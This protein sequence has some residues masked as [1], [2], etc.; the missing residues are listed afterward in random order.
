M[1][2]YTAKTHTHIFFKGKF[3]SSTEPSNRGKFVN[4]KLVK[5]AHTERRRREREREEEQKKITTS[6][7]KQQ[8]TKQINWMLIKRKIKPLKPNECVS[9]R[10]ECTKQ[11]KTKRKLNGCSVLICMPHTT[12]KN[13]VNQKQWIESRLQQ[14]FSCPWTR[15]TY[16][17][18]LWHMYSSVMFPFKRPHRSLKRISYL[19]E[20]L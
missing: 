11:N 18:A 6:K 12:S 3:K 15:N 8:L 16:K 10:A 4:D 7:E 5:R 20:V 14:D 13:E 2:A 1:S 19:H 17:N 9:E